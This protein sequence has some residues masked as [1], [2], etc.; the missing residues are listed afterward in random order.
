MEKVM[1]QATIDSV[2]I[3]YTDEGPRGDAPTV[4]MLHGFA[5]N[6]S[7]WNGWPASLVDRYRVLR[8]DIRGCGRSADPHSE[9]RIEEVVS[10][11]IAL[12]DQLGIEKLHYVGESTGGIVGAM[13]AATYP[14]RF[15]S[16]TL[17]STP[18]SPAGSNSQVKTPVGESP[19]ESLKML[20]LA[21]WWLRTRAAT[22]QLLGDDRDDVL[23]SEFA[24]TPLNVA[25]SMW[26]GMHDP[27]VTLSSFLPKLKLPVLV[28]TPSGSTT[29]SLEDQDR[30]LAAIP[31]ATQIIY[32]G[33]THGM[34]FMQPQLLSSDYR[35]FLDSL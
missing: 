29:T 35:K 10:D 27:R 8:P 5:R 20:G 9:F 21:E 33:A 24:L 26:D 2:A 31:N 1:P 17:V 14:E 7:F 3:H 18:I 15:A 6:G 22:G 23:A 30:L 12:A 19:V 4:L 11:Q 25:V 13:A 16:L 34:Y 32:Q 28:M